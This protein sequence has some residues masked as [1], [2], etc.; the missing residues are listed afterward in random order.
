MSTLPSPHHEVGGKERSSFRE[1]S[2]RQ[3]A[4][5]QIVAPRVKAVKAKNRSECSVM[6]AR[7]GEKGGGNSSALPL[8][9]QNLRGSFHQL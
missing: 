1:I 3:E 9:T 7:G 8:P 6:R 4:D 5:D 2:S